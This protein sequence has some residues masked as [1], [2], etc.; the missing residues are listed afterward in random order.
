MDTD[1]VYFTPPRGA[2]PEELESKIQQALPPGIEIELDALFPAMYSYKAKNYALLT[3]DGEI[4]LTGAALKSR[5]M[6]RYFRQV[7][8]EIL[9]LRLTGKES[10]LPAFRDRCREKLSSHQV[11][12]AD[13]CKNETLNDTP[14]NY[15]KKLDS[16]TGRRS[17]VY[18]LLIKAAL[19]GRVGDK[20]EYYIT[21][22]KAKV[23]VVD[24]SKLLSANE[25][26]RDENTALYLA[27]LDELFATFSE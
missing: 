2:A 19:P 3:S 18:E 24:N 15:K 10:E 12:L 11:P 21:G 26:E 23:A 5:G 8:K 20:V 13:L 16:G 17:A 25:G 1:G 6:E 22:T 14:A 9:R 7:V 4:K 27:K